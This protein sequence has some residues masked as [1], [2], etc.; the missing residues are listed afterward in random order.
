VSRTNSTTLSAFTLAI[1]ILL[2]TNPAI[3]FPIP[4]S[5]RI[6]IIGWYMNPANPSSPL[7]PMN[8]MNYGYGHGY[9]D[10]YGW[11]YRGTTYASAA[12]QLALPSSSMAAVVLGAVVALMGGL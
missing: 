9:G 5:D 1:T 11:G 10:G 12:G 6:G 7:N 2:A 8:S 3:A 4:Q